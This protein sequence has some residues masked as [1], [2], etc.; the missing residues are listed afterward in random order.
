MFSRRG[1]MNRKAYSSNYTCVQTDHTNLLFLQ[2]FFSSFEQK[3]NI[4]RLTFRQG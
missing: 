3:L 1:K 2:S 4:S